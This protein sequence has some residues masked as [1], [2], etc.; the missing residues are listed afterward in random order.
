MTGVVRD[1]RQDHNRIS[2]KGRGR[3]ESY[4]SE[5]LAS[6]GGEVAS[7]TLGEGKGAVTGGLV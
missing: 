7:L 1:Q 5:K 4:H 2:G 6:V 3:W